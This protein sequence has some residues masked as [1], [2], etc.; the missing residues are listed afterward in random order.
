MTSINQWN[1]AYKLNQAPWREGSLAWLKKEIPQ[2][3]GWAL[4]LG[5]GSGETSREIAKHGY[6][7]IGLDY[8]KEAITQAREKKS[9]VTFLEDNLE[10]GIL[11]TVHFKAR[12]VLDSKVLAFIKN[13]EA[14][15]KN[16]ARILSQDGTFV[17]QSFFQAPK[18]E[19]C[20]GDSEHALIRKHF[21]VKKQEIQVY[22][23][24]EVVLYVLSK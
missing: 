6:D 22:P 4:D 1:N 9:P 24:K 11:Q 20:I 23:E 16:I 8:S 18:Q 7:V 15:L 19:I 21:T 17:I 5:C 3:S 10:N 13:K 2:G 12:F 14:Y